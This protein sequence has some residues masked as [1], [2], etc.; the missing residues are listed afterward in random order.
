MQIP[1]YFLQM[2]SIAYWETDQS[3]EIK[4]IGEGRVI[5]VSDAYLGEPKLMDLRIYKHPVN[6]REYVMHRGIKYYMDETIRV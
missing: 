6:H 2:P 1:R 4:D 3:L 5:C